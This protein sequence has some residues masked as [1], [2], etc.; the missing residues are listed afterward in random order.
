MGAHVYHAASLCGAADGGNLSLYRFQQPVVR[1]RNAVGSGVSYGN[2]SAMV[3]VGDA[4][5]S[6]VHQYGDCGG[7]FV[8]VFQPCFLCAGA[9]RG[10]IQYGNLQ[11]GPYQK[12]SLV[13]YAAVH[14]VSAA[15]YLPGRTYGMVP[16]YD[17]IGENDY[18]GKFLSGHICAAD[19][20]CFSLFFQERI[21]I[22][23]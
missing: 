10:D 16:D 7:S 14:S 4:A 21:W 9:V 17:F 3:V 18:T 12:F 15:D 1:N 13:R 23:C 5:L 11:H 22:L 19:I 8:S 2:G 6:A 20:V